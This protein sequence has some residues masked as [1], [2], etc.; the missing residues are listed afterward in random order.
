MQDETFVKKALQL[1]STNNPRSEWMATVKFLLNELNMTNYL[2]NPELITT[3]KF[4]R[5]CKEKIK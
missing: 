4:T 2:E 1:I 3:E 5:I